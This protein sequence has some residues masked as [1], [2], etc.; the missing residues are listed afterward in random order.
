MTLDA[1]RFAQGM[2]YDGYKAQMTRNGERIEAVEKQVK[3]DPADVAYFKK[4]KP[5]KVFALAEDWCGDVIANLP[6]LGVLARETGALDVRVYLR[7]K[8]EDIRDAYL[9]RGKYQSIPVFVFLDEQWR[10]VGV[11][12]ERPHEV[13]ELRAEQRRELF[14]AHP[15][16]GD[17][18]A[19]P[20]QMPESVRTKY[21]EENRKLGDARRAL[22]NRLVVHAIRDVI[23][24]APEA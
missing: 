15:E 14:K 22:E 3:I 10:E 21:Q 19:P 20:D 6:V 13:T 4:L 24:R 7:D 16:F 9:N 12:I 1:A 17:L 2:P 11:F 8:N 5:L 18:G 23:A